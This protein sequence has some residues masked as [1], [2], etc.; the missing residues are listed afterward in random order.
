MDMAVDTIIFPEE[1]DKT[2]YYPPR[3]GSRLPAVRVSDAR[4]DLK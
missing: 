2:L 1:Q 3:H 4:W